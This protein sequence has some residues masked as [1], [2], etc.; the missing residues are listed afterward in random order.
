MCTLELLI[1]MP[2]PLHR[3]A[4][5]Q[6][7]FRI[8][9]T[10]CVSV[11]ERC[12]TSLT[13]DLPQHMPGGST[14]VGV[15]TGALNAGSGAPLRTPSLQPIGRP[16]A[17][18]HIDQHNPRNSNAIDRQK[19]RHQYHEK[20]FPLPCPWFTREVSFRITTRVSSFNTTQMGTIRKIYSYRRSDPAY[21]TSTKGKINGRGKSKW[22]EMVTLNVAGD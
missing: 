22:E 9:K 8:L 15:P 16:S 7:H 13:S 6:P 3:H 2:S 11:C 14:I 20:L 12:R 5:G 10:L 17:L 4:L 21:T 1:Y 19:L 18:V